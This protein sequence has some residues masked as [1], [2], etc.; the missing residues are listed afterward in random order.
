[1][2]AAADITTVS[3]DVAL[4]AGGTGAITMDADTFVEAG[5]GQ[6]TLAAGGDIVLGKL[7]SEHVG[8]T[9]DITSGGAVSAT[10]GEADIVAATSTLV[11]QAVDGVGTTANPI[12][13][14]VAALDVR[15]AGTEASGE[16]VLQ[17]ADDLEILRVTQE[18]AGGVDVSTVRGSI[19]LVADGSGVS[20]T[21]GTVKLYAGGSG[22]SLALHRDVRTS[23]GSVEL[24]AEDGDLT[25]AAGVRVAG[26]GNISITLPKGGL[27]VDP[28]AS[29]WLRSGGAFDVQADWAMRLGYFTMDQASGEIVAAASRATCRPRTWPTARCCAPPTAR[30]CRPPAAVLTIVARDAVGHHV[31]GFL[32][33]PLAVVVDALTLRVASS[34]RQEVAVLATGSIAVQGDTGTSGSRGG[35]T[36]VGSLS[37]SQ[38][39]TDPVDASGNDI[40]VR[41]NDIDIE[42]SV[43]SAGGVLNLATLDPGATIVLGDLN[44]GTNASGWMVLDGDD[45]SNLQDG[46]REIVVGGENASGH[47]MVGDSGS[48]SGVTLND[49]LHIQTPVLGGHVYIN[50]DLVLQG[51]SSLIIEGSGNTTSLNAGITVGDDI[52]VIDSVQV[53]GAQV[54]TAA[55]T[56]PARSSWV[57]TA[58]TSSTATAWPATTR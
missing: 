32:Y 10:G 53:T 14:E 48:D 35:T 11:I 57:A 4:T 30:S 16:I 9:V 7:R 44:D 37:G 13:I 17:E 52:N 2:G 1:M 45:L 15:N 20:A 33:S 54:L 56:A 49:T 6:I 27:Q 50:T 22:S 28:L 21:T 39:I 43:R 26:S 3:G 42:Q 40:S 19:D 18:G 5:T 34:E 29:G 55:P 51:S 46:F 12:V 23:G 31:E 8:G 58:R 36:Q 38:V 47:V 25:L 41:A 24:T